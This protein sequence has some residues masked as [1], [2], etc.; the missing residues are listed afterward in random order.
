MT[1]SA[2]HN[3]MA[4]VQSNSGK[5]YM[6]RYRSTMSYLGDEVVNQ[7]RSEYGGYYTGFD[8]MVFF[9]GLKNKRNILYKQHLAWS[10]D[11]SL[12]TLD[13]ILVDLSLSQYYLT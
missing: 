10:P 6:L 4:S 7:T 2:I 9:S 1:K 11:M 5:T 3:T 12:L 8:T 13:S